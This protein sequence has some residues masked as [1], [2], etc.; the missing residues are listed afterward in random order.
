MPVILLM[1]LASCKKN[2]S[3]PPVIPPDNPYGLPNATQVGANVIACRINGV[4]WIDGYSVGSESNGDIMRMSFTY[5]NSRDSM[6][7]LGVGE[8]RMAGAIIINVLAPIRE[9]GVYALKDTSSSYVYIS[10]N[11]PLYRP[12]LAKGN[13]LEQYATNGIVSITHFSGHY[14]VP[15]GYQWGAYDSTAILSGTFSCKIAF[16]HFDT[17]RVTDG[18]FDINYS[19]YYLSAYY[20][21]GYF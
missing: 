20:L 21:S 15:A 7:I 13:Y 11:S 17:L 16:P 6:S 14:T 18:R 5:S 2:Q 10:M 9:G 8:S 4:N 19:D 1:S 12:I 3:L